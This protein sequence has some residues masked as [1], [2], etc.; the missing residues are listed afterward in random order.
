MRRLHLV[1]LESSDF[2]WEIGRIR[3]G[4]PPVHAVYVVGVPR[5]AHPPD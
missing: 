5:H 3:L 2:V 1:E 4:G